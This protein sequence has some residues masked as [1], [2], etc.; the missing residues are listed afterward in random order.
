ML[1]RFD[2]GPEHIKDAKQNVCKAETHNAGAPEAT[3]I[4]PDQGNDN[5]KTGNN[6]AGG[7][8]LQSNRLL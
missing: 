4:P 1:F 3:Y 5:T 7:I 8:A 2:G 6:H